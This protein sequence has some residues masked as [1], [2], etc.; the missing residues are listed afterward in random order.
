MDELQELWQ[1]LR[2][3][4]R[5]RGLTLDDMRLSGFDRSY[6]SE[7]ERGLHRNVGVE[8]LNRLAQILE[9]ELVCFFWPSRASTL[10]DRLGRL[11]QLLEQSVEEIL[12]QKREDLAERLQ[13]ALQRTIRKLEDLLN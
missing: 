8:Y 5:S 3:L 4:R 10:E 1:T 11:E 13:K 2:S 6:L 7:V 12:E 9:V